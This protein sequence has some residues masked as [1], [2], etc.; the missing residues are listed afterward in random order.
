MTPD[1]PTTSAPAADS[2]GRTAPSAGRTA[3]WM[4]AFG[5]LLAAYGLGVQS[6]PATAAGPFG[7]PSAFAQGG[8]P[9]VTATPDPRPTQGYGAADSNHRMI[10]VTG[11]DL[12]GQSVLYLVDTIDKQ[13][14]IYQASGGGAGTSG[15]KLVGARRID[16][17]LALHG[18]NDKSEYKYK[19]LEKEF[20]KLQ[21]R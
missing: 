5:A 17:D 13:L 7:A 18:Y 8:N 19:D 2:A 15:V 3:P 20:Q 6:G 11:V 1:S 10:A 21:A 9:P 16:L 12:T 14:A 4:V